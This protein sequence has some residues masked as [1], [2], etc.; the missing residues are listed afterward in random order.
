MKKEKYKL[1]KWSKLQADVFHFGSG[2]QWDFE[3]N[4]FQ[5]YWNSK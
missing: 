3:N 5:H 1:V 4:V 2:G